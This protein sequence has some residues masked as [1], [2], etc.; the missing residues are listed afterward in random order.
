MES[1][2]DIR[3]N[4]DSE[5]RFEELVVS[6]NIFKPGLGQKLLDEFLAKLGTLS[7]NLNLMQERQNSG[8]DRVF[9]LQ[10]SGYNSFTE[11]VPIPKK[12]R[13]KTSYC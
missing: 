13:V 5:E 11:K 1:A 9:P 8:G 7:G 2:D 6:L 12:E 4:G 10:Q 3:W